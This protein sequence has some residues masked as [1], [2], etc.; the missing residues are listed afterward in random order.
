MVLLLLLLLRLLL[1]IGLQRK[2]F[3]NVI[4]SRVD[5]PQLIGERY[6]A[7][8]SAGWIT[9]LVRRCPRI[10]RIRLDEARYQGRVFVKVR[11]LGVNVR[12]LDLHQVLHH[13]VRGG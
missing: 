6:L 8:P 1:M 5:Q 9:G 12:Q 10:L 13:R 4:C 3:T 11:M 7:L 2:L